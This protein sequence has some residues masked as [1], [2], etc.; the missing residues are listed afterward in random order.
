MK[1]FILLA[2][3][4]FVL[5]LCFANDDIISGVRHCKFTK[6]PFK[7]AYKSPDRTVYQFRIPP[8]Q[9][10]FSYWDYMIGG[11]YSNAVRVQSPDAGDGV[12]ISYMGQR[13]ASGQRRVFYNYIENGGNI[14]PINDLPEPLY[15]QGY[16]TQDIDRE[17]GNP[18]FAWHEDHNLEDHK[19]DVC[20]S[21]HNLLEGIPITSGDIDTII[22][23]PITTTINDSTYSDNEFIWPVVQIGPSP[24]ENHRRVYIFATNSQSHTADNFPSDNVY[25]A[26]ADF[27]DQITESADDLNW[28]YASIPVL[29]NWNVDQNND[30]R[31]FKT[32][33]VGRDGMIF[34]VGYHVAIDLSANPINEP[35]LDVLENDN[36]GEGAWTMYSYD[37]SRIFNMP[38]TAEPIQVKYS[39]FETTHFTGYVDYANHVHFPL[40][41]GFSTTDEYY[42]FPML[43][44]IKDVDFN[45]SDHSFL[46]HDLYPTGIYPNDGNPVLPWDMNEDGVADSAAFVEW[47][48]CQSDLEQGDL[49]NMNYI[50]YT[51]MNERGM[52]AAVWSS[53]LRAKLYS[54][55]PQD[56]P[57]LAP[58]SDTPEIFIS[59]FP[60]HNPEH[61][62]AGSQWSEP[63]ALSSVNTPELHLNGNAMKPMWAYPGDYVEYL[64]QMPGLQ[65]VGKLH[66]MFYD[67]LDDYTE[68]G[69]IIPGTNPGGIVFYAALAIGWTY[70]TPIQEDIS[71]INDPVAVPR[72]MSL[73]NYPNPFNPNTT[74]SYDIARTGQTTLTIC[75]IKGQV[76]KHLVNQ[77]MSTGHHEVSWNGTSD[78][79]SQVAS[80]VYFSHLENGG[81]TI[82][83][84]M[85]LLK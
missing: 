83:N 54:E 81:K 8:E 49:F 62:E 57:E 64:G 85:V 51:R 17:T 68:C 67:D 27:D 31:L 28:S 52:V 71:Q 12:F 78:Q 61:T 76:V 34:L 75:N 24:L 36:Y 38:S 73:G 35:F 11:Y 56:Y 46:I 47:P 22:D 63:I 7:Y 43:Q 42:S 14:V 3:T 30:R 41:F 6:P 74:I 40:A 66:L 23:N 39:I 82:V 48:Y 69:N 70:G 84:K 79:G 10:M 32:P 50:Q 26:Y 5:S 2:I 55:S 4:I 65:D 15:R 53:S 16:I 29:D 33:V 20:A 44:S 60:V 77:S 19:L 25:Y 18:I 45:V 58:Y 21:L 1:H 37:P 59:V 72:K 9:V 13:T 80:G